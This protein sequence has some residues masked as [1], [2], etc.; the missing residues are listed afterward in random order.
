[1]QPRAVADDF[2]VVQL[3]RRCSTQ[4][5]IQCG[6]KPDFATVLQ[7]HAYEAVFGKSC[8]G[9]CVLSSWEYC[10]PF[11]PDFFNVF[12][13]EVLCPRKLFRFHY[14]RGAIGKHVFR[15]RG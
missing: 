11:P 15:K 8:H 3:L 4:T 12:D 10:I 1:M 7:P 13:D 14:D 5:A 6:R 2:D 9:R